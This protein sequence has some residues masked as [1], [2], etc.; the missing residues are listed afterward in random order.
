MLTDIFNYLGQL[1]IY[2]VDPIIAASF[3]FCVLIFGISEF[4]RLIELLIVRIF[5]KR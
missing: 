1:D 2:G 4:F 5:G 3:G